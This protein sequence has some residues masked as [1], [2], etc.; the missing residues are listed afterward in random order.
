MKKQLTVFDNEARVD[1]LVEKQ[2][3]RL[4][5]KAETPK[6]FLLLSQKV[7]IITK[8]VGRLSGVGE[9]ITYY[10]V[11]FEGKTYNPMTSKGV[12]YF[13]KNN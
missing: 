6:E 5:L 7:A 10:S 13:L 2:I 3:T 4:A 8:H 12:K 1:K 11:S 9:S